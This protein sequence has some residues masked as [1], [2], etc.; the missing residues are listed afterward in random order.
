MSKTFID[1]DK[2]I[3]RQY[4]ED[5]ARGTRW[6]LEKG[7][8]PSGD[9]GDVSLRDPNTGLI[10]ISGFTKGMPFSYTDFSEFS[11]PDMAIFEP[12]GRSITPW[13]DGTIET[14]M[15]LAI[16]NSRPDVNC[17][18]HNHPL[19]SSAF[20]I[21]GMDIPVT[22]AEQISTLGKTP[23]RTARFAPAGDMKMG[24][25]IVEALGQNNAALMANHGAVVCGPTMDTA[26]KNAFFLENIAQKVIYA[27]L[28][29]N[30]N[31]INPEDAH[32][33]EFM[34]GTRL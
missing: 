23:I 14:P 17:V 7:F 10:Y 34:K 19:W 12:D 20:A 30:I 11:A 16:Y 13:S 4:L 1:M 15:H 9:S 8:T 29:G 2:R 21:A 27:K 22:L 3:S 33:K 28:L 6:L 5:V 26:F 31:T 18:V 24:T 25:Y 32:P